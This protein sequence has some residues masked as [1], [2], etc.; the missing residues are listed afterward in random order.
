MKKPGFVKAKLIQL[1]LLFTIGS[2]F[3]QVPTLWGDLDKGMHSVGFKTIEA[4]DL[5]RLSIPE[6]DI[7][8]KMIHPKEENLGRPVHISI[9]YPAIETKKEKVL[10]EDYITEISKTVDFKPIDQND[11]LRALEFYT[12]EIKRFDNPAFTLDGLRTFSKRRTESVLNAKEAKGKFPIV[13]FPSY[14]SPANQSILSEYLASHGY[15]V[16]GTPQHGA[17]SNLPEISVTGI[18][19]QASDLAFAMA[20]VKE[21]PFAN[22]QVAIMG[23]GFN[24]TSALALITRYPEINAFVSLDGGVTVENEKR[25]L[26]QTSVFDLSLIRTPMMLIYS[27]HPDVSMTVIDEYKYS[28]RYLFQFPTMR[29]FDLTDFGLLQQFYPGLIGKALGDTKLGSEWAY[30]Y[31]LN[32]LSFTLKNDL[33]SGQFIKNKPFDNGV[34][35]NIIKESMK[36]SISP[37]P[38]LEELKRM[39]ADRGLT[40]LATTYETLRMQDAQPFSTK[41][42]TDLINW[43]GYLRDTDFTIR[44]ELLK[45]WMESHPNSSKGYFLAARIANAQGQKAKAMDYYKEALQTLESDT[46]PYLDNPTRMRIKAVAAQ[47]LSN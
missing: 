16:V 35:D 10:Y 40:G 27:K 46:D 4:H 20:Y 37:A 11:K 26:Q 25:M 36:K 9:W 12:D 31:V 29:E 21:L 3:G 42:M 6:L 44:N 34:P 43:L 22:H 45:I 38:T 24:A 32:F 17:G 5:S 1:Y 18:E 39:I 7:M 47:A 33:A 2:G 19:A 8:G 41:V 15:I 14:L 13:L 30:R 23:V 28:D